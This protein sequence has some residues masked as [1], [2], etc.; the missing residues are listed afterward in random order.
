LRSACLPIPLVL[1]FERSIDEASR[2]R[3]H[4]LLE[5]L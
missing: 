4:D 1:L 5:Q 2:I 3:K